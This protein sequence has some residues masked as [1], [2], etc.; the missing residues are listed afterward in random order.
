MHVLFHME[1]PQAIPQQISESAIKAAD[2]F[3]DFCLQH[4][5]YLG[6]RGDIMAISEVQKGY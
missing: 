2:R 3:V 5:A 6:G 4:A 1:N